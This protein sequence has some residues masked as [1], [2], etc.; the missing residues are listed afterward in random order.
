MSARMLMTTGG[1]ELVVRISTPV[2]NPDVRDL[3]IA[4]GWDGAAKFT[5][6]I[7]A[8]VDVAALT[9]GANLPHDVI[10]VINRGRLGGMRQANLDVL[11]YGISTVRRLRV[12]NLGTIFGRGGYGGYGAGASCYYYSAAL[13]NLIS[14]AGGIG[15]AGQGFSDSAAFVGLTIPIA[16]AYSGTNGGFTQYAGGI[17]GGTT[18]AWC[19]GGP[20]GDGGLIGATGL[21]GKTNTQ[22]GG[23]YV[24]PETGI[25]QPG[26]ASVAVAGDG[27]ITWI[28]LGII[29]GTRV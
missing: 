16:Q 5:L 26:S 4:A 2:R 8:G 22:F 6:E 9:I 10:T 12:L 13:A 1:G 21:V 17:I 29:Q 27:L 3:A 7:M 25:P 14:A 23:T 24:S 15:G 28:E 20:G 11:K 18:A 19:S